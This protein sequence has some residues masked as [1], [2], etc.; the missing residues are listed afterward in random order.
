MKGRK[1]NRGMGIRCGVRG[2]KWERIMWR[3]RSR[4]TSES[5]QVA[6]MRDG[7]GGEKYKKKG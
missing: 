6:K 1:V 5:V 2:G 3:E 4:S 7:H